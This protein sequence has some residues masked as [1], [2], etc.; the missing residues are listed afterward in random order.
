MLR[1]HTGVEEELLPTFLALE[2]AGAAKAAEEQV[3][4]VVGSTGV[5]GSTCHRG[6]VV[7][8]HKGQ[9]QGQGTGAGPLAADTGALCAARQ[10]R[11][12]GSARTGLRDCGASTTVFSVFC[13]VCAQ[14]AADVA[15]AAAAEAAAA[16]AAASTSGT[17]GD[18]ASGSGA[19][20]I[21]LL[22][23]TAAAGAAA[24]WV[25]LAPGGIDTSALGSGAS[26][27]L[28]GASEAV[29]K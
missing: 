24:A 5:G 9:L 28:G 12:R 3:R 4:P 16:S 21:A 19:G 25:L 2:E 11:A 15:A 27:A 29:N 10:G 18:A 20:P 22:L 23:A 17:G 13:T 26:S 6:R 1:L 7:G 14:A 8:T